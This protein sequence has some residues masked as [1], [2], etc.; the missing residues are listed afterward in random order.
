MNLGRLAKAFIRLLYIASLYA[1]SIA[2]AATSSPE[3]YAGPKKTVFVDVVG[4]V[5]AMSG[6]TQVVGT[7]NEGLNAMLVEALMR[8]GRFIVVERVALGDIQLEQ[9]LGRG[10]A[11]AAE[12]AAASG[13]MLGASA[14][15]RATVTKFEPNAGGGGLQIGLP[16]SRLLSG[17]AS[18]AGQHAIVEF[19]LRIIDTSTGQ[20]VAASKASGT[21]SST[22]TNVGATNNRSGAGVGGTTFQNTPLGEAAESAITAAVNQITAGMSKVP[23]S[24]SIVAFDD[25][26]VYINAGAGQNLNVGTKLHVYRKDKVLTDPDTGSLL[27]ILMTDIGTIQIQSV[28]EKI[29]IAVLT[30]G[31]P[32]ARGDVVKLE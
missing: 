14:I 1:T 17:N 20:I 21:A 25:S 26:K 4:A 23:W 7:T 22:S 5:E 30:S 24:A 28:S 3:L 11:T 18:V 32:P 12:T 15:V 31:G 27:E 10:G 8:S 9:D 6:G 19:S 2:I 16:F 29:S 13:R